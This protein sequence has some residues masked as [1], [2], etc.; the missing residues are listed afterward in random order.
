M[1]V[2]SLFKPD[3]PLLSVDVFVDHPIDFE[4]LYARSETCA[5]GGVSVRLVSIDDLIHLKR[6]AGRPQ[7]REDVAKLEEIRRLKGQDGD[8]R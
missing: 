1:Q 5:V 8:E 7:D 6:L 4:R 2:F 3:D